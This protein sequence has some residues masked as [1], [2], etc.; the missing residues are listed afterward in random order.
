MGILGNVGA[1]LGFGAPDVNGSAFNIPGYEGL[2]KKADTGYRS[3]GMD[4]RNAQGQQ[5]E[6]RGQQ[7]DMLQML[8]ASANGTGPSAAQLQMQS[9]LAQALRNQ[10][11]MAASQSS[12]NPALAYRMAAEQGRVLQNDV[13][14]NMGALRAQEQATAQGLYAQATQGARGQ[15]LQSQEMAQMLVQFYL[16]SGMNLAQAQAQARM[17]LE[18]VKQQQYAAQAQAGASILG[19]VATGAAIG[20]AK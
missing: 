13:T 6:T 1:A 16:E 12:M 14:A 4:Y 20:I 9:G 7:Q 17:Q 15:D 11:A 19:G 18:G 8:Q 5:Q 2:K 10:N 3:A